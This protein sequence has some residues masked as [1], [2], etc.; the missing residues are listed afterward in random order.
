MVFENIIRG[1]VSAANFVGLIISLIVY[2]IPSGAVGNC[3]FKGDESISNA[4]T[5]SDSRML[6]LSVSLSRF[7]LN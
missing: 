3:L 5:Y 7:L 2:I 6:F 4:Q 1:E